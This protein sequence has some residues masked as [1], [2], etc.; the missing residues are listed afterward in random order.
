VVKLVGRNK[1][2]DI[3]NI[4]I[5]YPGEPSITERQKCISYRNIHHLARVYLTFVE[6]GRNLD[7]I[8]T[9]SVDN[10]SRSSGVVII[11]IKKLESNLISRQRRILISYLCIGKDTKLLFK[12]RA[13]TRLSLSLLV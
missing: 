6:E 3:R 11:L 8:L 5:F 4:F 2:A 10:C 12:R 1:L 7:N 13:F 9:Q